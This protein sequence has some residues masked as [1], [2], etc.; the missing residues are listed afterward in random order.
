MF[1]YIRN[2][3][4]EVIRY[5]LED[6]AAEERAKEKTWQASAAARAKAA[7]PAKNA[8][9]NLGRAPTAN[10]ASALGRAPANDPAFALASVPFQTR[11]GIFAEKQQKPDVYH[12]V[13]AAQYNSP[14]AAEPAA[15]TAA[16]PKAVP[17]AN[18]AMAMPTIQKR[19][20]AQ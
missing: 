14:Q 20:N 18:P 12:I 19:K 15:K 3:Q 6:F 17:Y 11:T 5:M 10:A 16:V 13:S 8:V 4:F 1:A 2:R 9:S 7:A